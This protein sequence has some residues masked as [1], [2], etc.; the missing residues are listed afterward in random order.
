M[1]IANKVILACFSL[2]IFGGAAGAAEL[3]NLMGQVNSGGH[4]LMIRHAYAPGTGDPEQFRIGECATQRNLNDQG[5]AQAREIGRWLRSQGVRSA[6]VFSSQWCRCLET[7]KLIGLGPVLELPSLNSFFDR[8][9][10]AK[11]NLSALREFLLRQPE[12]GE[13]ILMV[14]HFVTISGITGLGVSSGEGVVIHL[15][16]EAGAMKVLGPIGFD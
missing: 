1:S 13:L 11:P 7:A 16:G 3:D 6:R 12:D 8:P 2:I 4:V 14:T 5:R 15:T 10:D 9:Q